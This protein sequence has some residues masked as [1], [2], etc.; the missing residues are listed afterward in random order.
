MSKKKKKHKKY[1]QQQVNQAVNNVASSAGNMASA[2]NAA[3]SDTVSNVSSGVSSVIANTVSPITQQKPSANNDKQSA[4]YNSHAEEYRMIRHD[5]IRV[6]VVN[7]LF[8]VAVLALYYA[9]R[10]HPFLESWYQKL[11]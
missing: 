3:V 10:S 6:V 8:L 4:F 5:L 9:N 7:G 11:F 2:V 1:Y